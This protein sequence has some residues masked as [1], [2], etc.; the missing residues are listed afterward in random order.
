MVGG[1]VGEHATATASGPQGLPLVPFKAVLVLRHN[2]A[3]N[4]DG[5]TV[6]KHHSTI[7]L[8]TDSKTYAAVTKMLG[9]SAPKMAEQGLGQFQ[10]FFSGL[11]WYLARHPDQVEELLK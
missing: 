7:H 3:R 11:S 4:A 8:V 1:S 9:Q 6:I 2:E 10:V 5:A